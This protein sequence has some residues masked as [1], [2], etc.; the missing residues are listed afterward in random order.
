MLKITSKNLA[1]LINRT[2]VKMFALVTLIVLSSCTA[3]QYATKDP[4]AVVNLTKQILHY[5]I[6][7]VQ[8]LLLQ[9][10]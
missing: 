1:G 5:L 2:A 6:K 4:S 10:F 8:K 7:L 3:H 9:L